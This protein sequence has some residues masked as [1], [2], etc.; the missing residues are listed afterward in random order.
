MSFIVPVANGNKLEEYEGYDMW[1]KV[2][3]QAWEARD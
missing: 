2:Y 3:M 1:G